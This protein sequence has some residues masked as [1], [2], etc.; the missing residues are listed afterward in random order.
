MFYVLIPEYRD[1]DF[2]FLLGAFNS[3][4][5]NSVML[6]LFIEAVEISG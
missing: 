5:S 4:M 2:D 3:R 6:L 1:E